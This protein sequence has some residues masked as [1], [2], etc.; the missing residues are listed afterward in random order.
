MTKLNPIVYNHEKKLLHT[1]EDIRV[2][3][4]AFNAAALKIN[5]LEDRVRK[6]ER[7]EQLRKEKP[8]A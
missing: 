7:A 2:L 5:S 4:Q 1:R 8:E 3:V 6:L